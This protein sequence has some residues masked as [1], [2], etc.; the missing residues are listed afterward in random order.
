MA[1]DTE[2]IRCAL[3]ANTDKAHGENSMRQFECIHRTTNTCICRTA[4]T[5]HNFRCDRMLSAQIKTIPDERINVN[6]FT[7]A[8]MNATHERRKRIVS[9]SFVAVE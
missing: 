9:I 4:Y 6:H 5:V 8:I 1:S 7:L 2:R 3:S